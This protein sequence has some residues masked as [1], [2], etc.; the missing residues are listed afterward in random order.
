MNILAALAADPQQPTPVRGTEHWDGTRALD[1]MAD[2]GGRAAAGYRGSA[3]DCVARSIAIASGLPYAEVYAALASGT[4][5]QRATSTRGKRAA[6][7]RSGINVTRKWF[8]DYMQSLGLVWTPTMQIGSGCKVHLLAGELP[9]GRLV[10]ALSKH[11]TAVIDGVIHDTFDPT[12]ATLYPDEQGRAGGG[13]GRMGH[14]CV[15]GY[16]RAAGA[17]A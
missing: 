3:G 15:Y 16:W 2:D 17:T 1:Y 10:V 7:A 9:A 5:S 14:R 4:G 12:R 11:Y 13:F 6:S 8:K